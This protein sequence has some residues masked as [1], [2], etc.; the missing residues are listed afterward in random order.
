MLPAPSRDWSVFQQIFAEHWETFQ[1]AHPRYQTP[2]YD[3]LVAQDAGLWQPGEDGLCRIPLPALWPG[4][5]RGGDEL[6]SRR[7]AYGAPKSMRITGSVR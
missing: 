3:G 5:A 7:C 6:S 4:Q 2:Y 1:Q